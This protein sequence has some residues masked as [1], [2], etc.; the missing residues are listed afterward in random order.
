MK[1]IAY[2][3]PETSEITFE[4]LQM[5]AFS[6]GGDGV[7]DPLIDPEADDSNDA[8]R[9]R[10]IRNAWEDDVDERF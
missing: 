8:N 9:S 5:I 7:G 3:S 2:L 10:F 1:K 6:G 4:T